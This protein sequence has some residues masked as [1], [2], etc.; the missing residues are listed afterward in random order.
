MHN[1]PMTQSIT[2]S[3]IL[4][5]PITNNQDY[6]QHK[7]DRLGIRNEGVLQRRVSQSLCLE[8]YTGNDNGRLDRLAVLR[9]KH[10]NRYWLRG[11]T[12]KNVEHALVAEK[13][14]PRPSDEAAETN[15]RALARVSASGLPPTIR[16]FMPRFLGPDNRL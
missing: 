12:L 14:L 3:D 8:P 1:D 11:D 13:I 5:M 4:W 16:I 7:R 9:Y 2:I 6:P 15:P 10:G